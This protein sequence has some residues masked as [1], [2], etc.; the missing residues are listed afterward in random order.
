M[1]E[2]VRGYLPSVVSRDK[3]YSGTGCSSNMS[4]DE[5]ESTHQKGVFCCCSLQMV[6]DKGYR[7]HSW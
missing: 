2:N 3:E 7:D 1:N 4:K 6:S 5:S